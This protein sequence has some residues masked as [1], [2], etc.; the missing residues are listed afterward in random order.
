MANAS[1]V[2][3]QHFNKKKYMAYLKLQVDDVN[4]GTKFAKTIV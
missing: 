3:N 2:V 1:H 4:E